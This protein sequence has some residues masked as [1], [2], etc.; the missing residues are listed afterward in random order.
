[1]NLYV[2]YIFEI[3]IEYDI[4]KISN[5]IEIN[6]IELEYDI[7]FI[8]YNNTEL[9]ITFNK[10]LTDEQELILTNILL[11]YISISTI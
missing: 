1:M 7:A 4:D 3:N 11:K 9:K 10:D 8:A 2:Y 6:L 5:L